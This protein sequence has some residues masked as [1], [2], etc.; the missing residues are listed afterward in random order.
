MQATLRHYLLIIALLLH[1][2]LT[3]RIRL[4]LKLQ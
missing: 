3:V 1:H 4:E 2:M